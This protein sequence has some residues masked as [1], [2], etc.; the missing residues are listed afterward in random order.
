MAASERLN[1]LKALV[2]AMD[3]MV[4]D[5]IPAP[6]IDEGIPRGVIVELSGPAR[7]E[8]FLQLL[9]L[10]PE[11]R[12]FWAECEQS[13]LPTAI[14]QRGVDLQKIT[15]GIIGKNTTQALRRVLQSQLFQFVIAPNEFSELRTYKA[16]QL[17]TEKSNTTLFL[18]GKKE[19]ATAWPISLQLSIGM[20]GENFKIKVLKKKH[21]R[22]Q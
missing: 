17:L 11:F 21:G 16:F 9:K 18:L 8:W 6:S 19:P 20:E 22:P 1:E 4:R 10:H 3:F 2:G 7:T 12:T 13:V 14:H 5:F 15:F